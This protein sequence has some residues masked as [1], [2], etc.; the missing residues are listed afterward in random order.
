[1]D[2]TGERRADLSP[3]EK[4]ERM[5]E[6]WLSPQRIDFISSDAEK[7]YR[8]RVTRIKDVLELKVPDRIPI[9]ANIGF[10][11]AY[12]AG[13]S[14]EEAVSDY[15]KLIAAWRDFV[16]DL[17]P[18]VHGGPAIP[19]PGKA[20]E[21]LDYTLYLLP[22][23]GES[24]DSPRVEK[25]YMKADEYDALIQ[26][27]SDFMLRKYMPRIFGKLE[28]FEKSGSMVTLLQM[29]FS[30]SYLVP[31][32]RPEVRSALESLM[33]AGEEA[34][35]WQRAVSVCNKTMVEAGY[36]IIAGSSTLAPYDAI[37]D[38]LRGTWGVMA[39]IYRQP[40]KLIEAMERLTP[41][42]VELGA[43]GARSTGR[44]LVLIPLHKGADGFMSDEQYRTFYW[45][46]LKKTIQGLI[47]EGLVPFMFAEGEYGTRLE[48]IQDVPVGKTI[49]HFDFTDMAKAKEVLAGIA[50]I[51][52]NVPISLL[53]TGTAD[54]VKAYCKEL[55]D[56][57]GKGG[58]FI[59]T[60]DGV[61]DKA[62]PENV[63]A[64]IDFTKEHGVY[65]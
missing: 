9:Y 50:C 21:I 59:M 52:G 17:Q 1:M 18:D 15:D 47:D 37:A 3:E 22:G 25:E 4:L 5:F 48:V 43:E 40:D 45:P 33:E 24:S 6:S 34:L 35:K 16:L 46:T 13:M 8:E 11:P 42:M 49:W 29:P 14:T 19:G 39:D 28:P 27:P 30:S 32:G 31:F 7:A 57:A 64:M 44:P 54:E 36:P 62:K 12:H 20:Y 23:R 38:T 63:R 26:D 10:F 55:I 53:D 2:G 60:S 41:V 56:V 51:A 65:S 61:I 58:G